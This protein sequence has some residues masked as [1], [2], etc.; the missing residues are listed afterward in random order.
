MPSVLGQLV[1]TYWDIQKTRIAIIARLE[2]VK[3]GLLSETADRLIQMENALEKEIH[4][5]VHEHPLWHFWLKKIRGMG[6][7][8]AAQLIHLI[9]GKK[10]TMECQRR[11]D[12]Y[13]SKKEVGE[14]REKSFTCDCPELEIERFENVSQLWHYA[15]LIPG[16]RR[17]K[18]QKADWNPRLRKLM[19]L[20]RKSFVM[21][22]ES[23]YR[24]W[25]E[26]FRK[27]EDEKD[28]I[29]E[30]CEK[31]DPKATKCSAGHRD[32]KARVKVAKLFLAHLYTKWYELKGLEPPK[33][34]AMAR[35]GHT[36]YIPPPE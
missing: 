13:F 9:T 28:F 8:F 19:W 35:L 31:R 14:K 26:V 5:E 27:Y 2:H 1:D 16:A 20:I 18:G 11:R 36:D 24:P 32:R 4:Y 33:P 10:H 23:Q 12:E 22:K 15:G 6:E 17:K 7:M 34:Y 3:S 29:C 30:N 21:N 25:Y